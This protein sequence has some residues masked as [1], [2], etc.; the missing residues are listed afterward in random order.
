M[1]E[2]MKPA[3]PAMSVVYGKPAEVIAEDLVIWR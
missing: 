3:L 2:R 1:V